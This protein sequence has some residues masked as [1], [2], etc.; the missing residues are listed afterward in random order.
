[1]RNL[2]ASSCS[3]C[4]NQLTMKSLLSGVCLK[5]CHCGWTWVLTCG[6]MLPRTHIMRQPLPCDN[7]DDAEDITGDNT[8][9]PGQGQEEVATGDICSVWEY[10]IGA[11]IGSLI[12]THTPLWRLQRPECHLGS[13]CRYWQWIWKH[14]CD[15]WW[16]I[17]CCCLLIVTYND[18]TDHCCW[19]QSTLITWDLFLV[20][21]GLGQR[22]LIVNFN[23]LQ[24]SSC[25]GAGS[26]WW[27]IA[28]I[29][30]LLR[31]SNKVLDPK[32]N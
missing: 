26:G 7:N 15:F 18:L 12:P 25:Q 22:H 8:W 21:P 10:L 23:S 31:A 27:L 28:A 3:L 19:L 2:S 30:W 24:V 14:V 1:M 32:E 29:S 6:K 9:H 16:L 13:L 5:V 20:L 17:C 4:T 11:A